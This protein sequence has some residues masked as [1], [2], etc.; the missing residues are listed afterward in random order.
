[1]RR[2]A[3]AVILVG[4]GEG[5]FVLACNSGDDFLAPST[6]GFAGSAS[7]ATSSGTTSTSGTTGR[8]EGGTTYCSDRPYCGTKGCCPPSWR[9]LREQCVAPG[10]T[11]SSDAECAS[12]RYCEL[13]IREPRCFPRETYCD[14]TGATDAGKDCLH[15]L[16]GP[17]PD[18]HLAK[19]QANCGEVTSYVY[20]FGESTLPPGAIIAVDAKPRSFDAGPEASGDAKA[21]VTTF[22]A[23][24]TD[25]ILPGEVVLMKVPIDSAYDTVMTARVVHDAG[26]ATGDCNPT[27][28]W[29]PV[30]NGC[31]IP[32]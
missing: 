31:A 10:I 27:N 29:D 8:P 19:S 11:C 16:C 13:A 2:L 3:I 21:P 22:T 30:F 25:G 26:A 17:G 14:E 4:L 20:N 18:V 12:G 23:A 5:A 15:A 32:K 28:D 6:V 7:S 9:C 24:T 1:M